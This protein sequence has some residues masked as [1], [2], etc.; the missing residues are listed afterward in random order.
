MHAMLTDEKRPSIQHFKGTWLPERLIDS[1]WVQDLL[2]D[3]AS[4]DNEIQMFLDI[5]C[6]AS[7]RIEMISE[8]LV[9]GIKTYLCTVTSHRI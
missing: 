4:T 1:M 3:T 9:F 5:F 2:R 7:I 8:L 6:C